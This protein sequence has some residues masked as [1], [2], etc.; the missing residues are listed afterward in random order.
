M[1]RKLATLVDAA[2]V[3]G[4][5]ASV[6]GTVL[7]VPSE[8]PDI[9][10][11]IDASVDGDTVLVSDG[12]YTGD[13]NRGIDFG[14][15]AI[16]VMSEDGPHVTVIDC[17]GKRSDPHRGFYFHCGEDSTS[18]VRGFTIR[19]GCDGYYFGAIAIESSSPTIADNIITGNIA[20]S[21]G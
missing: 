18:V 19:N 13:G 7:R 10:T 1:M 21:S 15:K 9:Q 3:L 11:G 8:Y 20:Y 5:A 14:G 16:V 2:L 4:L 17:G 6:S 12:I